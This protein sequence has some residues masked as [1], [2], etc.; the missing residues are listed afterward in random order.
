M[1]SAAADLLIYYLI[2]L[3]NK[4]LQKAKPVTSVDV[5]DFYS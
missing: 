4:N 3:I 5:A 2:Y 1:L